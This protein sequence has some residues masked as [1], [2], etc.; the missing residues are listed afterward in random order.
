MTTSCTKKVDN[1]FGVGN[2]P[3]RFEYVVFD[4]P[5]TLATLNESKITRGQILDKSVVLKDLERQHTDALVGLAYKLMAE[6]LNEKKG[7][8]EIYLPKTESSIEQQLAK[9]GWLPIPGLTV[10]HAKPV[11]DKVLARLGAL[12]VH[13]DEIPSD[14]AVLYS[15]EWRRFVEIGSQL[16]SQIARIVLH[17]KATDAKQTIQD[18]V[19]KVVLNG[20]PIAISDD[21]LKA[22]LKKIGFSETEL[23]P[24]LREQFLQGMKEREQQRLIEE[25]V[26]ENFLKDP[27]KVSFRPPVFNLN[28]PADWKPTLGVKDAPVSIVAFGGTNC[29]D[30]EKFLETVT[31]IGKKFNGNVQLYWLNEFDESD[32]IARMIAEGAGCVEAQRRGKSLEFLKNFLPIASQSDEKAFY[33][34]AEKNGL[35]EKRVEACFKARE[36]E[37]NLKKQKDLMRKLGI[38]AQ[39]SLWVSGEMV[40]AS[41]RPD[42][43]EMKVQSLIEK[44][45]SSWF[46]ALIR[47]IKA[48][49]DK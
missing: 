45:G 39:P 22:Y 48:H 4:D 36:S 15:I 12:T 40:E 2:S 43:I 32:G 10:R 30:C 8:I 9:H 17:E 31:Q 25:Y 6:K 37:A 13:K 42:Q 14:N 7:V 29:P 16:G 11:D 26:V 24:A 5:E 49:F 33:S 46:G 1:S 27:L 19:D 18:Y 28:I 34:W 38:V 41:Q 23:T 47:R 44:S 20:K 35:D 3:L 21:D